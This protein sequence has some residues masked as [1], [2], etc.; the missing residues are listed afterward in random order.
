MCKSD[1]WV[2]DKFDW[3]KGCD[4]MVDNSNKSTNNKQKLR[5]L[6][7]SCEQTITCTPEVLF[8]SRVYKYTRHYPRLKKTLLN[9]MI[10]ILFRPKIGTTWLCVKIGYL[11][12]WGN[13]PLDGT[14]FWTSQTKPK[15]NSGL[16]IIW[17][18]VYEPSRYIYIY[19][20]G[21]KPLI[22]STI[23]PMVIIYVAM[24]HSRRN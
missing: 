8:G 9:H 6:A 3:H 5:C 10:L 22:S 14:C 7:I 19:I 13:K 16:W 20:Y 21:I 24:G 12:F 15:K 11:V 18:R 4:P 23:Y 2:V 17:G 1:E